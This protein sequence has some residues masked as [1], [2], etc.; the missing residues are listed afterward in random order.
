MGDLCLV[1][2]VGVTKTYY[3]L[4]AMGTLLGPVYDVLPAIPVPLTLTLTTGEGM[5]RIRSP[6]AI[7]PSSTIL[8]AACARGRSL[9]GL[10][11]NLDL[12]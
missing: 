7:P 10:D 4:A 9:R 5:E 2:E 11:Q 8:Q 12:Q 1:L 3:A 6:D